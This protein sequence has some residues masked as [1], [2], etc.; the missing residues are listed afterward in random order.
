MFDIGNFS[1]STKAKAFP[2]L[3][4]TGRWCVDFSLYTKYDLLLIS[5]LKMDSPSTM[6]IRQLPESSD[7][8]YTLYT[9]I[10]WEW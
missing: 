9:G 1:L 4:E 5:I 3:T 8:D 2:S 10:G 6:T 7:M